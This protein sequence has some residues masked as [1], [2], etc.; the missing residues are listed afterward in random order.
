MIRRLRM[1]G[2]RRLCKIFFYLNRTRLVENAVRGGWRNIQ[3]ALK[4]L[5]GETIMP[6]YVEECMSH[7]KP[8]V[9]VYFIGGVTYGEIATLRLLG[10][11]LSKF[12]FI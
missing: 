11:I 4:M 1:V 8:V 10:K 3:K 9:L 12:I 2:I 6:E 5:P 7:P